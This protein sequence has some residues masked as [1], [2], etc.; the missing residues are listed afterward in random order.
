MN[1]M[2]VSVKML[3]LLTDQEENFNLGETLRN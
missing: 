3:S 1:L 2:S